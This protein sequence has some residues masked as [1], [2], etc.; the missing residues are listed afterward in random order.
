MIRTQ[1]EWVVV[2]Q[3]SLSQSASRIHG[4]RICLFPLSVSILRVTWLTE[5]LVGVEEL[6]ERLP[7]V[8]WR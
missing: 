4:S 1:K 3:R 7:M 2:E 8:A 6:F 5:E